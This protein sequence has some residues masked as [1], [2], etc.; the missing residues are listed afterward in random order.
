MFF[1]AYFFFCCCCC[2]YC[3]FILM[4]SRLFLL[5][6][7]VVIFPTLNSRLC[8]YVCA[9]FEQNNKSFS[10]P[11]SLS[12]PVW[13]S[14][15]I[16]FYTSVC[17]LQLCIHVYLNGI[18][19]VCALVCLVYSHP[20]LLRSYVFIHLARSLASIYQQLINWKFPLCVCVC[21]KLVRILFLCSDFSSSFDI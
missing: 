18:K 19:F 9:N 12:L 6:N 11:P 13:P 21:A 10:L 2:C 8:M 20:I 5:F 16:T 17:L 3:Y 1:S 7:A 4:L 15:F 14:A